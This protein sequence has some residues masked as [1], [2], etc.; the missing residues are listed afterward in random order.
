MAE[1][2]IAYK[3]YSMAFFFSISAMIQY[4]FQEMDTSQ[5]HITNI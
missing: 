5:A 3:F 4:L 1:E 2:L